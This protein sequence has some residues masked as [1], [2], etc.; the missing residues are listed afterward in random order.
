MRRSAKYDYEAFEHSEEACRIAFYEAEFKPEI[1]ALKRA[2]L[3][4]EI[5]KSVYEERVSMIALGIS[6]F[7]ADDA[8]R[9]GTKNMDKFPKNML[10]AR[11]I[12][13]GVRWFCADI[14]LGAPVYTPE[15]LGAT[16]D[17]EGNVI[18][19]TP[20]PQKVEAKVLGNEPAIATPK[21]ASEAQ[22][23]K[24]WAVAKKAGWRV[25]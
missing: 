7:T 10:F 2:L 12:S 23:K 3:K 24:I 18:E 8:K 16:A 1:R 11:A 19:I 5:D 17:D 6:E 4:G 21:L 9:V 20:T 13:N 22:V 25:S 14:F 15:E